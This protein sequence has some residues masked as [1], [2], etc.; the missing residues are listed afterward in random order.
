MRLIVG[1]GNPEPCYATT[2]HN[3]GFL[4]VQALAEEN[5]A[6][7]RKASAAQALISR[8]ALDDMECS[9]V[10]PLTYMNDSGLAV[11]KIAAKSGAAPE[12]IL[13]VYDDM[14]LKFGDMR[15]RPSGSAGGHNGIKSI[16]EHLGLQ[17]FPRLRLG[18]GKP[19]PGGD[20]ADYVLSDFTPGELKQ[21]PDF[22]NKALSCVHLWGTEGVEEA[23]NRFNKRKV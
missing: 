7:W 11:K 14:D 9:L 17:N 22:I 19:K 12:D 23:M 10:L 8:I 4:V 6:K 21:L 20:S 13:V 1:L 3:F 2:R 15:I 18:V 5:K 16:I